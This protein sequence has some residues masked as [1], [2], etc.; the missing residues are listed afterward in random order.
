MEV[1]SVSFALNW[2]QIIKSLEED[3]NPPTWNEIFGQDKTEPVKPNQTQSKA[4]TSNGAANESDSDED[5]ED[6]ELGDDSADEPYDVVEEEESC[7]S[8]DLT[9]DS[10]HYSPP[11]PSRRRVF[12]NPDDVIELD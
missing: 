1:Y 4:G 5:D 9:D 2:S 12:N 6:Y 7:T 8:Y 3:P 10:F 11:P